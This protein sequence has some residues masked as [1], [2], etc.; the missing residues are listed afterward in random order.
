MSND[1]R[2]TAPDT[3]RDPY[4][5]GSHIVKL[6]RRASTHFRQTDAGMLLVATRTARHP[7]LQ[8]P[9]LEFVLDDE[10]VE[11]VAIGPQGRLYTYTIVHPGKNSE[12]YALAMVDFEPNV[13]AFGRLV[14]DDGKAPKIGSGVCVVPFE[15]ADGTADYAFAAAPGVQ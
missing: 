11:E 12:P 8:F 6:K 14:L 10:P 5:E 15:M 1:A 3:S 4:P 9:P 2:R 7:Q 13:R